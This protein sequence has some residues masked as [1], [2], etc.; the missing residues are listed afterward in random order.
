MGV[1]DRKP[2]LIKP[3]SSLPRGKPGCGFTTS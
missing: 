1:G 2:Q 3:S